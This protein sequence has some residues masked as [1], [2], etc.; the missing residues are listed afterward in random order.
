MKVFIMCLVCLIIG[1]ALGGIIGF[2]LGLNVENT[3]YQ[4]NIKDLELRIQ[5]TESRILTIEQGCF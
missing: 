5:K 1:V 4:T 3:K 2:D